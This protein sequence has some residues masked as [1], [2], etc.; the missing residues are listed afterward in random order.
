MGIEFLKLTGSTVETV[1]ASGLNWNTLRSLILPASAE[2]VILEE[3]S[4]V[5]PDSLW[6]G[7]TIKDY[8][9]I[10]TMNNDAFHVRMMG[11][12]GTLTVASP[13]FAPSATFSVECSDTSV[14]HVWNVALPDDGKAFANSTRYIYSDINFTSNGKTCSGRI[15]SRVFSNMNTAPSVSL[16]RGISAS[17]LIQ[18]ASPE[19][20]T[21]VTRHLSMT[22]SIDG[23]NEFIMEPFDKQMREAY[24]KWDDDYTTALKVHLEDRSENVVHLGANVTNNS[25]VYLSASVRSGLSFPNLGNHTI[26]F[27]G[28]KPAHFNVA[29][30]SFDLLGGLNATTNTF[31]FSACDMCSTDTWN[32]I[33]AYDNVCS[34]ETA[35]ASACS[36]GAIIHVSQS[37]VPALL[38]VS[39]SQPAWDPSTDGQCAISFNPNGADEKTPTTISRASE[40]I[41]GILTVTSAFATVACA[42]VLLSRALVAIAKVDLPDANKWWLSNLMRDFYNDQFSWSSIVLTAC[43]GGITDYDISNWNGSVDGL[44]LEVKSIVFGWLNVCGS[45]YS[46]VVINSWLL[47][48][49]VVV[50]RILSGVGNAKDSMNWKRALRFIDPAHAIVSSISL[51]LLPLAGYAAG[52]VMSLNAFVGVVTL[53][54]GICTIASIPVGKFNNMTTVRNVASYIAVSLPFLI[55]IIAG[56][57]ASRGVIL[58]FIIICTI[59]LPL[60]N[61]FVLWKLYFAGGDSRTKQWKNSLFFTFGLRAASLISGLIF[62]S[63]LFFNL[64]ETASGFSYAFWFFW[65]FL[66]MVQLIPLVINTKYSNAIPRWDSKSGYASINGETTPL[67]GSGFDGDSSLRPVGITPEEKAMSDVTS[68]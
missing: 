18:T 9:F 67:R 12:K 41:A 25:P 43:V 39:C 7:V 19:N 14:H 55:S 53:L 17:V 13:V 51:L 31:C 57:G 8:E 34:I 65:V 47:A 22:R 28:V 1:H 63:T 61:T 37:E 32:Q 4:S 46:P 5:G 10:P 56:A 52:A 64:S 24:V 44:I 50:L 48:I 66:P 20:A 33:R 23:M 38:S 21:A 2:N 49:A 54:A 59:V 15:N 35:D 29:S 27:E 60:C 3:G 6:T 62:V 16:G 40:V 26:S 45:A 42:S 58:S 36:A 68:A 11:P 30:H